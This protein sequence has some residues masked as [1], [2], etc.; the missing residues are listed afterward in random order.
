MIEATNLYKVSSG[1]STQIWT[2]FQSAPDEILV[3]WGTLNGA[4]QQKRERVE[5]NQSGRSLQEQVFSRIESRINRQRDKGYCDTIEEAKL[6]IGLNASKLLKPMLAQ[7]Y[8]HQHLNPLISYIQ[9]KYNGHRCLV[10][11][12]NDALIAYSRNGKPITTID[13][14][15]NQIDIPEG[16]TLDGELYIHGKALQDIGS[17]V[18]KVQPANKELKLIVYD[19]IRGT[20]F[21]R[22]FDQL[23]NYILGD[24]CEI[25]ETVLG[26]SS[27]TLKRQAI[28]QMRE[29][30]GYEGW[31]VRLNDRGY[32]PGKRSSSLLKVKANYDMEVM[33]MG[34]FR[35]KDDVVM[36]GFVIPGTAI[37][38]KVTAPGT[39]QEREDIIKYSEKYIGTMLTI[40]F[41]ELTKDG[42]PF[43]PVAVGWRKDI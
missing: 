42:I 14:I 40:E 16:A 41:A 21:E 43:H 6:S 20:K 5:K 31:M 30:T 2:I 34:I 29:E 18:R 26:F 39:V 36:V 17:I 8:A 11:R 24:G 13:H 15:L 1:N 28:L 38:G 35:S 10:T 25:A 22:R 19:Q 32:E 7:K 37:T 12:R 33:T 9:Y 23:H 4:L 27:D 3:R